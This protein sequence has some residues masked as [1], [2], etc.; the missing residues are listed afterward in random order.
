MILRL[1]FFAVRRRPL[2]SLGVA[3]GVGLL[4]YG[5]YLEN[6]ANQAEQMYRRLEKD[7]RNNNYRGGVAALPRVYDW[8]ALKEYW[9]NRPLS[10][11]QR[12][13]QITYHLLPCVMAYMR[14]F[15]LFSSSWSQSA[16]ET[17]QREHAARLREALTQLGPA[18]VKAGQQL[19]IRPDLVPP[20]VL[21]ELQ[22]LCDAVQP[23]D[24]DIALQLLRDELGTNDLE[25][26]FADLKL[27]ASASLGQVY[28]GNLQSTGSEVAI[29]VQR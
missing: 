20:A 1:P 18:F 13:G 25:T 15:Y 9:N 27:V 29:K 3:S 22:K 7:S 6:Q 10:T 28:K 4:G 23:V 12:L 17:L 8:Q 21:K 19:S 14:D 24:D 16:S 5:A 26:I 2:T 11:A